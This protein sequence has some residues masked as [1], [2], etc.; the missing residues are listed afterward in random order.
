VADVVPF[1][2]EAEQ[3]ELFPTI[4]PGQWQGRTPPPREWMVRNIF[5]RRNVVI[6]SGVGGIG[7]SL[8]MQQL[9]TSAVLGRTWIGHGTSR[10]KAVYFGCEDDEDELW[11]RQNDI[12][13]HLGVEQADVGDAGLT[14]APRTDCDNKLA[15]LDR[16][17]W[18]MRPTK[19]LASVTQRCIDLGAEYL[20]IDTV[21]RV[22]A[23]NSRDERHVLEFATMMR[24]IATAMN[25]VVILVMHPS[26]TGRTNGSGEAG[27]VQWNNAVR[28]RVYLHKDKKDGLVLEIMKG[29]YARS[30][31]K[32]PLEWKEGVYVVRGPL[33]GPRWND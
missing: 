28:S 27:S 32:I 10:G 6:C 2:R 11:R 12:N 29:N 20:V 24:R 14:L 23:G 15:V 30:G 31:D 13:R 8:L 1:R 5:P 21:A 25:G 18:S 3:G 19:L 7:K 22:F 33:D 4:S 26:L 16:S 17:S 9:V